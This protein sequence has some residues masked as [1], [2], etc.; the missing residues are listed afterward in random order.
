[1]TELSYCRRRILEVLG[2]QERTV[3]D[4]APVLRRERTNITRDLKIMRA[5]GLVERR[6]DGKFVLYRAVRR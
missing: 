5:A 2:D 3:T 4:L 1:M 6:R